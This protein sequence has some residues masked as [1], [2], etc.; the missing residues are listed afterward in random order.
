M[1]NPV[2]YAEKS[3]NVHGVFEDA[4]ASLIAHG[5]LVDQAGVLRQQIRNVAA[6]LEDREALIA[7]ELRAKYHEMSENALGPVVK[8]A[9]H[10][11]AE[12]TV[13]RQEERDLRNT[14]DS[15][16][17]QLGHEEKVLGVLTARMN[18]LGGLLTFYAARTGASPQSRETNETEKPTNS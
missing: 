10:D 18:E 11:D 4:T 14:L 15:V 1:A 17:A 3:L 12:H 5:E 7:S 16:D 2:V 9:V 8:R 6:Q 13:L